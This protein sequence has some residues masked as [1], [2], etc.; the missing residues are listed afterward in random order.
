MEIQSFQYN[1]DTLLQR[2][3][4]LVA[5]SFLNQKSQLLYF[6]PSEGHVS[7]GGWVGAIVGIFGVGRVAVYCLCV[8]SL[9][10]VVNIAE[11]WVGCHALLEIAAVSGS[12][13]RRSR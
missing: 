8:C 12:A 9:E 1:Y 13:E 7:S 3:K 11:L 6:L 5:S 2:Q 10:A 4:E